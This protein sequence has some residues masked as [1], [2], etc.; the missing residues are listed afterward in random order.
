ML[1]KI[2]HDNER[3]ISRLESGIEESVLSAA[4]KLL[5]FQVSDPFHDNVSSFI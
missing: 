1:I 5:A 4:K 3:M 2:P